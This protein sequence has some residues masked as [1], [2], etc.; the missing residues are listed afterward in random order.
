MSN[1]ENKNKRQAR[2]HSDGDFERAFICGNNKYYVVACHGY[3]VVQR[4]D[5]FHRSFIDYARDLA[6][7]ITLIE[8]DAR[9]SQIK[10]A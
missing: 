9:S 8:L 7:A 5:W 4:Q 6:E 2:P 1:R 10:A 3:F